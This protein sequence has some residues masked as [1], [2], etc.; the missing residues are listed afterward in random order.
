MMQFT[1]SCDCCLSPGAT[2]SVCRLAWNVRCTYL[3]TAPC[4]TD[5]IDAVRAPAR[6][7]NISSDF[8]GITHV[9]SVLQYGGFIRYDMILLNKV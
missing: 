5:T 7:H 4:T 3:H 6:R 2:L 8:T 9:V 1:S